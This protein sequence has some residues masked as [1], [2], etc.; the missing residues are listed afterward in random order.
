MSIWSPFYPLLF[1][2]EQKEV[3][4]VVDGPYLSLSPV[5]FQSLKAT[6]SE[7]TLE[8]FFFWLLMMLLNGGG[9]IE[10]NKKGHVF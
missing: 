6:S 3:P 10:I 9:G 1:Y 7:T 4:T 2:G 5:I 8:T